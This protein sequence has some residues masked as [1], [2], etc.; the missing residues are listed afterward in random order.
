MD[1]INLKQTM[2]P[3][4]DQGPGSFD[5]R[6]FD[7]CNTGYNILKCLRICWVAVRDVKVR[8]LSF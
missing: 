7:R 5:R 1:V 6:Y 3:R 8:Y 2:G 4:M